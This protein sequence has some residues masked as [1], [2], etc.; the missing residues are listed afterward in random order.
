MNI[1]LVII[2]IGTQIRRKNVHDKV[3]AYTILLYYSTI[4]KFINKNEVK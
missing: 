2:D 3:V 1:Y 4:G